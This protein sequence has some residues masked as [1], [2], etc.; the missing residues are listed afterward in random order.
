MNRIK[1]MHTRLKRR[2]LCG[3]ESLE[4]RSLLTTLAIVEI[5][6]NPYPPNPAFGDLL[7]SSA[8]DYEFLELQNVGTQP[9]NLAGV[10]LARL[11]LAGEEQGVE[12]TFPAGTLPAGGRVVV[13]ENAPAFRARYGTQIPVAGE[14]QG[15]L[16]NGGELLTLLN[17]QGTT[18][19]QVSY[20]S[21]A[22][23]PTRANGIGAAL[24]IINPAGDPNDPNNWQST[25][26]YGG[27]PGVA[28]SPR[29]PR[30]LIN[31][32]LAHTDLPQKDVI[33]LRNLT[34]QPINLSRW[35]L[36]D[37]ISSPY[38]Y[39]IPNGRTIPANGYFLLTE[40]DFNPGGGTA[41]SDFALSELGDEIWLISADANGIPLRFEDRVVFL[42]TENTPPTGGVPVGNPLNQ[43]VG[44]VLVPLASFTPGRANTGPKDSD[45]AITEF[46]YHPPDNDVYKQFIEIRNQSIFP[47][48]LDTWQIN[49]A[50]DMIFPPGL[51]LDAGAT[52]VL[53]AFD[54]SPTADPINQARAAAFRAY[55]GIG[56]GVRL[57]GPWGTDTAGRPDTLSNDGESLSL[58]RMLDEQGTLYPSTADHVDYNDNVPWPL[59]PDGEGASLTR[60]DPRVYG[61]F[62]DNWRADLP[63]PGNQPINLANS[64]ALTLDTPVS[65][66]LG[67]DDT[68]IRGAADV[69][70]FR[71]TAATSATYRFTAA[72]DGPTG[73][74]TVLRVFQPN[75]TEL[76][77]HDNGE[78]STDA[79]LDLLL[80]AGQTV[81]VMVSGSSATPQRY[82]PFTGQNMVA[83]SVGPY[84]LTATNPAS[85]PF[86]WHNGALPADVTG[87]GRVVPFDALQVINRLNEVGASPLPAPTGE[88]GP[89][90]F[91]DVNPDNVLSPLDALLIINFLNEA[92][93]AEG[94][95]EN[96]FDDGLVPESRDMSELADDPVSGEHTPVAIE[97]AS[98]ARIRET[99]VVGGDITASDGGW[100]LAA[101]AIDRLWADLAATGEL[102]ARRR[103]R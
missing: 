41:E 49:D 93:V 88:N 75:G 70:S 30:V 58:D 78:G 80:A 64:P 81:Y 79:Q 1:S 33:E 42:A 48:S 4:A 100:S 11:T 102:D 17:A 20:G 6:Y 72:G 24:E 23:W 18:I 61:S 89:P 15:G 56:T 77:F 95:A 47:Q 55:Y 45:L 40:D 62:A 43:D 103:N 65:A 90:P 71:F 25:I 29:E 52:A 59:V 96:P 91:Y 74:D 84:V 13:V 5:N 53:V 10:R 63:S 83:G 85:N 82:N 86:P 12:F 39:S 22:D 26:D 9:V 60:I 98:D 94:E 54:P 34:D 8:G 37:K 92:A 67:T 27:S 73:A 44:A 57:I 2:T 14:W 31:E 19:F 51:V 76:A 101:A 32:V 87:D 7:D 21:N 69:D 68:F 38:L 28:S 16:G 99:R 66:V 46:M 97:D 50:I 36:S 35:Y 3:A